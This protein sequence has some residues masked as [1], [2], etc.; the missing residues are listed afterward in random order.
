MSLDYYKS[1]LT[2]ID[3]KVLDNAMVVSNGDESVHIKVAK[4]KLVLPTEEVLKESDWEKV[5]P[6]HPLCEIS[7][8]NKRSPILERF[9]ELANANLDIRLRNVISQIVKRLSLADDLKVTDSKKK[10]KT[11]T[12]VSSRYEPLPPDALELM[13]TA[14]PDITKKTT[15]DADKI[16]IEPLTSG[17][18]PKAS[19]RVL[20]VTLKRNAEHE[21]KKYKALTKVSCV[22]YDEDEEEGYFFG[23]KCSSKA[24]ARS[25][26]G[27]VNEVIGGFDQL[28]VY[29]TATNTTQAPMWTSY[30]KTMG[31]IHDHLNGII[32]LFELDDLFETVDTRFLEM[33]KEAAKLK[34]MIPSLSDSRGEYIDEDQEP[35]ETKG[36]N[37]SPVTKPASAKPATNSL[38]SMASKSEALERQSS[39]SLFGNETRQS[40]GGMSLMAQAAQASSRSRVGANH[41]HASDRRQRP[42]SQSAFSGTGSFGG[43]LRPINRNQGLL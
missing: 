43:G 3:S 10:S 30:T 33:S 35:T 6:F 4:R 7:I 20:T 22:P 34:T 42:G 23:V 27:I 25:I 36:T 21:S 8:T 11:K 40:T 18:L 1:V 32:S 2:L 29:T 28:E 24:S 16:F 31:K 38:M 15:D 37:T 9:I 14:C 17:T 19:E 41:N 39:P 12:E 26:K 13:A 5:I